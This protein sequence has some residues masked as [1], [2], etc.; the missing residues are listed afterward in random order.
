MQL[1]VAS[2]QH[3]VLMPSSLG[4][5]SVRQA[6]HNIFRLDTG[7]WLLSTGNWQLVL[8]D[9]SGKLSSIPCA[10]LRL[11]QACSLATRYNE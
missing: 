4:R 3:P 2:T 5:N 9:A 11:A 10:A 8:L 6:V 1:P 7:H